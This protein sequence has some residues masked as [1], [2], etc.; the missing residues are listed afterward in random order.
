VF[1]TSPGGETSDGGRAERW[2]VPFRLEGDPLWTSIPLSPRVRHVTELTLEAFLHEGGHDQVVPG[3]YGLGPALVV[4]NV[5]LTF[6]GNP[7]LVVYSTDRGLSTAYHAL[8]DPIM[9]RWA[10]GY[11]MFYRGEKG[12]ARPLSKRGLPR[13][14]P[15]RPCLYRAFSEDDLLL[16]TRAL[17]QAK[18]LIIVS[19]PSEVPVVRPQASHV[20][21]QGVL[22]KDK[23]H[24]ERVRV[25]CTLALPTKSENPLPPPDARPLLSA[26]MCRERNVSESSVR[27]ELVRPAGEE[28]GRLADAYRV[29][30]KQS[31]ET[32]PGFLGICR[33]VYNR[34]EAESLPSVDPAPREAG[35]STESLLH[36]LVHALQLKEAPPV[37]EAHQFIELARSI[38]RRG[39][40]RVS[41]KGSWIESHQTLFRDNDRP[42]ILVDSTYSAARW[43]EYVRV[44]Q[45]QGV[46]Y[47]FAPVGSPR[48]DPFANAVIVCAAPGA[49]LLQDLVAGG[50]P[51]SSVL[52]YP[53]ETGFY[54]SARARLTNHARTLGAIGWPNVPEPPPGDGQWSPENPVEFTPHP[55]V[56]DW[57]PTADEDGDAEEGDLPPLPGSSEEG[58]KVT[59]T[60]ETGRYRI[61]TDRVVVVVRG[62][63]YFELEAGDAKPGDVLVVPRGTNDP[64]ASRVVERVCRRNSV[65]NRTR[66]VAGMWRDNLKEYVSKTFPGQTVAVIHRSMRQGVTVTYPEFLHWL[67]DGEPI[68]PTLPNL[69]RLMGHLGYGDD[70]ATMVYEEGVHHKRDRRDILGYV[71]SLANSRLDDLYEKSSGNDSVDDRLCLTVEDLASVIAFERVTAVGVDDASG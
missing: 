68:T 57:S 15:P 2:H 24:F 35:V 32:W 63:A 48:Q 43:R 67:R 38:L 23:R 69:I 30:V 19:G 59:L 71:L 29:L 49:Q 6:L 17:P 55:R 28:L 7:P 31:W 13:A 1:A 8:K 33:T 51:Q 42:T 53:W 16:W 21:L 60:T 5:L 11:P 41:S 9:G 22:A 34:L 39:E 61:L 64:S 65:M 66:S 62:N 27:L 50:S 20:I 58:V 46:R 44:H 14:N 47:S 40:S 52:L 54:G 18:V 25:P 37:P 4:R 12:E 10:V 56:F 36:V 70:L 26:F 3:F 45:P